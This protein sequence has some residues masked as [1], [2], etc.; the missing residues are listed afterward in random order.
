[1][2]GRAQ[3]ALSGAAR[4]PESG[5]AASSTA[6]HDSLDHDAELLIEAVGEAARLLDCDGAMVYLV[7]P[8]GGELHFGFDAGVTD[9]GARGLLRGL[10]LPFGPGSSAPRSPS[11]SSCYTDDYPADARFAHHQVAD[12]VVEKV[13]LRSMAA[14]PDAGQRRAARRPRRV[15]VPLQRLQRAAAEPAPLPRRPCGGGHRQPPAAGELRESE[16]RLRI[17]A[18]ELERALVAQRALDEISRRIV[19]V[20]D[21]SEVLQQIVDIASSLLG[22]D[23]AHLTLMNEDGTYLIPMVMAGKTDPQVRAWLHSQRFPLG[24]GINGLAASIGASRPG[25][26]TTRNDPRMPHDPEDESP[27][28]LELGAVAVAPLARPRRR[29]RRHAGADLSAA[30]P[31]R[32]TRRVAARR[33]RPAGV[34]RRAQLAALFGAAPAHERSRDI[35]TALPPPRRPFARPGLV[36]RWRRPAD[37][38]RRDGRAADRLDARSDARAAVDGAAPAAIVRDCRGLLEPDRRADPTRNSRSASRR[39]APMATRSRPR[40]A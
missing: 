21:S 39:R 6:E 40:S 9:P 19:D 34:D 32:R 17:Q 25:P 13:G 8:A 24:G 16:E 22:S 2:G 5:G 1:M 3:D 30:A 38:R 31:H 12:Q 23:G 15:L 20:D 10:R 11:A 36:G 4:T 28:R 33:P 29:R 18:A 27:S 7:D 14:A 35:R 37:L 26:T